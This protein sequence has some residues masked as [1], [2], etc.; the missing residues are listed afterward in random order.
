MLFEVSNY[1]SNFKIILN[2]VLIIVIKLEK[3]LEIYFIFIVFKYFLELYD[4]FI[5]NLSVFYLL[6]SVNFFN[7]GL[8]YYIFFKIEYTALTFIFIY[9][10]F[11]APYVFL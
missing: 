3:E 10:S 7:R 6:E 5:I 11:F 4:R 9:K 2:S 1:F 8:I